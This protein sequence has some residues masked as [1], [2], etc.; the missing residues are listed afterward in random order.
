MSLEEIFHASRA[1]YKLLFGNEFVV[2]SSECFVKTDGNT[3][4]TFPMKGTINADIEDAAATL[5]GSLK[6][7]S[8]HNTIV[9]L[10]RNDISMVASSTEVK[11]YR[12]IERKKEKNDGNERGQG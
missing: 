12:Y 2:F 8:E 7:E 10:M 11:R 5:I 6:E 3:I 9:D 4:C 1:M